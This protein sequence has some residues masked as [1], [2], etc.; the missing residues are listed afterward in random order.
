MAD[1]IIEIAGGMFDS[2]EITETVDGFPV[3]NK[4]VG[5]D[6]FAKMISTLYRNGIAIS[7]DEDALKITA[8]SGMNLLCLPGAAWINGYM[9]WNKEIRTLPVSAGQ[10]YIIC[11]RLNLSAGTYTVLC[12]E[13]P[14]EGAYPVRNDVIYDLVL[15]RASVPESAV[16]GSDAS[17][18]DCRC[19]TELCGVVTS[20]ADGLD[21]IAFASNAGMLGGHTADE[22]LPKTGGNMTGK[23]LAAWENTGVAAVRNISYGTAV[24]ETLREGEIFILLA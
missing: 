1:T 18:E 12:A 24:P 14:E 21:T 9:A 5:S 15:A 11:L 16:S 2:T 13:N 7:G 19:S 3:G 23:L 17:I 4:A 6:F 22:F 8:G 20:A 10:N